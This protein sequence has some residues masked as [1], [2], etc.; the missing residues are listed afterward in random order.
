MWVAL[1]GSC[2]AHSVSLCSLI[3]LLCANLVQTSHS[4]SLCSLIGLL[5]VK[6]L[7][8]KCCFASHEHFPF[9]NC[10]F[11]SLPKSTRFFMW[12]CSFFAW[13]R[14]LAFWWLF[15]IVLLFVARLVAPGAV[16]WL[17]VV[18]FFWLTL[19]NFALRVGPLQQIKIIQFN[20]LFK[21]LD[22]VVDDV[23]DFAFQTW[24]VW[25]A[26]LLHYWFVF[27]LLSYW[28]YVVFELMFLMMWGL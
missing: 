25:L 19:L 11:F 4:I 1:S 10:E 6:S 18:V 20:K 8:F 16:F 21:L 9:P 13:Q 28:T 15:C 22:L 23:G 24:L 17:N 26:R 27:V 5:C 3:I 12:M 7:S 2:R 14:S